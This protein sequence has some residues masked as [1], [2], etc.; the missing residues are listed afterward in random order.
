M[1]RCAVR[2]GF[3]CVIFFDC[4][5][6][7]LECFLRGDFDHFVVL[8]IGV[9]VVHHGYIRSLRFLTFLTGKLGRLFTH[10]RSELSCGKK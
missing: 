5:A 9:Q 3:E 1:E 8:Y 10:Y 4:F 2:V 7:V 6:E